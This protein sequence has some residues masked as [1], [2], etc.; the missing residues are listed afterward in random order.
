MTGDFFDQAFQSLTGS[1]PFGWQRRLFADHF[2]RGDIP[3]ALDIP[4]GL[5]K[6]L[7]GAPRKPAVGTSGDPV[8]ARWQ[9]TDRT[10]VRG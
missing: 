6:T 3:A 10:A 2:V 5:G 1:A 4:T 8:I 7:A 9:L